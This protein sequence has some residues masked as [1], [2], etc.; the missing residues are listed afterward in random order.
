MWSHQSTAGLSRQCLAVCGSERIDPEISTTQQKTYA[1]GTTMS[2]SNPESLDHFSARSGDW[3]S[4]YERPHFKDRLALFVE[5]ASSRVKAGEKVLDYGCGTGTLAG[6]LSDRFNVLGIDGASG[7]IEQARKLHADKGATFEQIDPDHW[8]GVT[9][10]VSAIV[11]SSVIEYVPDD[12]RL[13]KLFADSLVDGGW[14]LISV[15]N[16]H[17]LTNHARNV[18]RSITKRDSDS[19]YAQKL[20]YQSSTETQLEN[21]GFKLV[22]SVNFEFPKLGQLGVT[23]SRSKLVGMMTLL[24]AQRVNR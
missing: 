13:L 9:E 12:D 19:E 4:L 24:C 10:P 3:E 7:M 11:C 23:L 17:S 14:L 1:V 6:A 21:C 16:G 2:A 8:T 18:L 20:Y 5:L 22:D 15:P